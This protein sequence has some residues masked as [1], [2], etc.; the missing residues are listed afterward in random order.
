MPLI[1]R[2]PN[3]MHPAPVPAPAT[4]S[5]VRRNVVQVEHIHI[6]SN[7]RYDDVRASL[8]E[9]PRFDD[10]IRDLLHNGEIERVKSELQAIQGGAHLIL[11]SIAMHGDWLQIIS[12]K[13]KAAQ[14]VIGN[15]LVSTRMTQYQ[16]AAGLYAP[17]RIMLYENDAGT[18]TI[19][20][21]RPSSLFGQYGDERVTAVAQELDRQIYD[22]LIDAAG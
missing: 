1:D 4:R 13:R 20:Y 2:E 21:D 12:R 19:E 9:L 5:T 10:R 15:V 11:F 7:R 8:E 6:D 17:L 22:V 16:L 18:A 3:Q 14:Y